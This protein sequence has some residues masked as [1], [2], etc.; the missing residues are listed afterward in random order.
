MSRDT[1]QN[2][3]L[4]FEKMMGELAAMK[5]DLANRQANR[6]PRPSVPRSTTVDGEPRRTRV[7][8]AHTESQIDASLSVMTAS[9]SS[10]VHSS[11]TTMVRSALESHEGDNDIPW[12]QDQS[13]SRKNQLRSPHAVMPDYQPEMKIETAILDSASSG[14]SVG[15]KTVQ[16]SE[17]SDAVGSA[18]IGRSES[19]RNS[20]APLPP[21][22]AQRSNSRVS[23]TLQTENGDL[24]IE[25]AGYPDNIAA[26]PTG[27]ST[28][29]FGIGPRKL[30]AYP[31]SPAL[32]TTSNQVESAS[33][34]PPAR[35][36]SRSYSKASSANNFP[37]LEQTP[38]NTQN[39][40][41]VPIIP[42]R[43]R[44][45]SRTVSR[46]NTLTRTETIQD[47][48]KSF[49]TIAED[50][51][52]IYSSHALQERSLSQPSA[53][54][55][56]SAEANPPKELGVRSKAS[57]QE[58]GDHKPTHRKQKS[59]DPA[60]IYRERQEEIAQDDRTSERQPT[61]NRNL[62]SVRHS[63]EFSEDSSGNSQESGERR[64]RA[65]RQDE[66]SKG[67]MFSWA[68]SRSKS[69]DASASRQ[70]Q[71]NSY[72]EYNPA[73]IPSRSSSS[74]GNHH[75]AKSV[76]RK[77]SN[78]NLNENKEAWPPYSPAAL[79]G[80]PAQG[81]SPLQHSVSQTKSK[82]GVNPPPFGSISTSFS[83]AASHPSSSISVSTNMS[84]IHHEKMIRGMGMGSTPITP[85]V[86]LT[87]QP[88]FPTT[89]STPQTP[90][91]SMRNMALAMMKQDGSPSP[92]E[93][94]MQQRHQQLQQAQ[95]QH[96][97]QQQQ[98]LAAASSATSPPG[99][100]TSPRLQ[101][102]APQGPLSPQALAPPTQRLVATRIYIQ[103]EAD[104]KSLNL[105][106][107]ST[108]LDVL[109]MLQQRGTFGEP[110]DS[111]YHDRWTIFEYSKEFMIE[112]PL[113]DF[114]V[115]LDVMKTWEADKDNK[116][117]CK[118]FP[119]RNELTAR[120]IIRLVGPAGKE[121]FVS[122]HGW[123]HL[124]TKKSKWVKRYL[125]ITDT[126]VYHSKDSKFSGE[127]M[128]CL[129]RNFDVYAVQVPR[130][131]APTKFGFAL[132][133]SDSIHMFETPED[134]YIHYV[135]TE[136]G[137][138]LREWLAGLR[139][140]KGMSM[141]HINPEQIRE[142]QKRAAELMS[143]MQDGLGRG[144]LTEEQ[145]A[146]LPETTTSASQTAKSTVSSPLIAPLTFQPLQFA[147][148]LMSLV[149]EEESLIS[150]S[151]QDSTL[152]PSTSEQ[153]LPQA[154]PSNLPDTVSDTITATNIDN[155]PSANDFGAGVST[156]SQFIAGSLLQQRV[157]AE[158]Q[159]VEFMKQQLRMREQAGVLGSRIIS[160][161]PSSSS[162]HQYSSH[163]RNLPSTESAVSLSTS[164]S[165]R[166][167][168][169]YQQ[170]QAQ[171]QAS[172][173]FGGSRTLVERDE[174]LAAQMERSRSTVLRPSNG[175]SSDYQRSRSRSR[176][177]EGRSQS[178][179]T[180]SPRSRPASPPSVPSF[181]QGPLVQFED[182]NAMIKPGLLLSRAKSA[183]LQGSTAN[184]IGGSH[185]GYY[186]SSQAKSSGT[187]AGS[188][189]RQAGGSGGGNSSH[190]SRSQSQGG[191]NR[192]RIKP[193]INLNTNQDVIGPG[194]LAS[195][196][197]RRNKPL[198]EF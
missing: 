175:A 159:E 181:P 66:S 28:P 164:T 115:V 125:H 65:P 35:S 130:K 29:T 135:C 33:P 141:Y 126:A 154:I 129:L 134:D 44:S 197:A 51:E 37:G 151:N 109:Q 48:N 52:P 36:N 79:S 92:S 6:A 17:P 101:T 127:S 19:R 163:G 61:H 178:T 142:G 123:V 106:S 186:P 155:M 62:S 30:R 157:E 146:E 60:V 166:P 84:T 174:A 27:L 73:L 87:P 169:Q 89:T 110:G 90:V 171:A 26:S 14:S 77:P 41:Q 93:L 162:H 138:S 119:A 107:N 196:A 108:A 98:K 86:L 47:Q 128:L 103:N 53:P 34:R 63:P 55:P 120:E 45:G 13:Q 25:S 83:D 189:G 95:A 97:Q 160:E 131:K 118:S 21:K 172:Q 113:R 59:A 68:R 12:N 10:S 72:P 177:P 184:P 190:G 8:R 100:P 81:G 165:N 122:P 105:A 4:D 170:Q 11:H 114:E 140:A 38:Q 78:Q 180:R 76:P 176:G 15:M 57:V 150:N 24:N 133:S 185:N 195:N 85:A 20:S 139:A 70:V 117:I 43:S 40:S 74:A 54:P 187:N 67:G 75:R 16:S 145:L 58:E 2:G 7:R 1:E 144:N 194:L 121:S 167:L 46:S 192:T 18:S 193:L 111:R 143:G 198:V 32:S 88:S 23:R 188:R 94:Q 132:K 56:L 173:K 91:G 31:S 42:P 147:P 64:G 39:D 104:F 136:S 149:H 183:K 82:F 148:E 49:S 99:T 5:T 9:E 22:S 112:R 69:K 124:E 50:Q 179:R 116:M 191:T 182:P 168:H 80:S 96:I 158:K 153:T 137:E 71:E 152:K 3:D 102:N 156:K 161:H